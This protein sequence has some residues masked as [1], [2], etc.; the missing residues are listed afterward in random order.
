M[1]M[2]VVAA[3]FPEYDAK[4]K[5][6]IG[7]GTNIRALDKAAKAVDAVLSIQGG[8]PV[9]ALITRPIDAPCEACFA[10]E[11][12]PCTHPSTE[13]RVTVKWFHLARHEAA[14][15]ESNYKGWD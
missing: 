1:I 3:I 13:G 11:G 12:K 2:A 9:A 8:V 15:P 5:S 14:T 10:K 4:E 7:R 6:K